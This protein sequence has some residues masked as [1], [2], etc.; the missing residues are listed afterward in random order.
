MTSNFLTTDEV[1]TIHDSLVTRVYL[2]GSAA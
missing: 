1:I 2:V